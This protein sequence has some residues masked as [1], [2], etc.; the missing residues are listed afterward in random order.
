[1][2]NIKSYCGECSGDYC[3]DS[4][5][6]NGGEKVGGKSYCNDHNRNNNGKHG[7]D[8]SVYKLCDHN[9]LVFLCDCDSV[10]GLFTNSFILHILNQNNSHIL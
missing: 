3:V 2:I 6:K 8:Q 1:M 5:N 7:N 4:N 10:Q 9:E